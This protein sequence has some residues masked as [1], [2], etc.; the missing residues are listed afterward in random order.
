MSCHQVK[1]EGG[2]ESQEPPGRGT[3]G[4]ATLPCLSSQG[5]AWA[6][7]GQRKEAAGLGPPPALVLVTVLITGH[8]SWPLQLRREG[9]TEE[10]HTQ[11][12][13]PTLL[14]PGGDEQVKG[15]DTATASSHQDS[16]SAAGQL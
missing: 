5:Q 4:S 11:E 15:L 2:G 8:N 6:A 12:A 9:R 7:A 10:A 3:A 14:C 13:S 1:R 16:P